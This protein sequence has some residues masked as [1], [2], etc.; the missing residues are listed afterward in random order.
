MPCFEMT[1]LPGLAWAYSV[2]SSNH[3]PMHK[4]TGYIMAA[5]VLVYRLEGF[6]LTPDMIPTLVLCDGN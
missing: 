2:M 3:H 6:S 1:Q 5:S 4:S